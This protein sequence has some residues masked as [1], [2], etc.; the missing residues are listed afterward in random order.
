MNV[1]FAVLVKL[2]H[3]GDPAFREV[4]RAACVKA[5][6]TFAEE[7]WDAVRRR[8][9]A[10]ESGANVLRL[11]TDAADT[12]VKGMT[13]F[14][15]YYVRN[16]RALLARA[17]L[18][19][20]GGYGR[21]EMSPHSD[22]DVCLL[23]DANLD[24]DVEALNQYLMPLLWDIG[25]HTGYSLHSVSE[26]IEL[27]RQDPQVST[28]YAQARLLLGDNTTFARLRLLHAELTRRGAAQV[29]RHIRS[30]EHPETLPEAQRDLYNLQPDIKKNVGGLRDYHAA[31]WMIHYTYGPMSLDDL[32]QLG[33]LSAEERLRLLEALGFLWRIRN[34][35][36]FHTGKDQDRLTFAMQKHVA[37]T[38]GYGAATQG[39][40]DRFMQDYY[41]AAQW[42]RRFLR[43]ASR[44]CDRQTEMGFRS[45]GDDVS[46]DTVLEQGEMTVRFGTLH[47]GARDRNW[48]I[49]RPARLMEVFWES[50]RRKVPLSLD[51][52]RR[53][54][55]SLPLVGDAFCASDVVRRYFIAICSQPSQ[56]GRVL[57]QAANS[58]LLGA[59]L[60]EFAA[61]QGIVR[62]RDFHSFPV[63]E[64]TLRAIEA[65]A[66]MPKVEGAT[67]RV[68]EKAF[69]HV[70]DPHILVMAILF[71]DLGKAAGEAHT[72]EGVRLVCQIGARIGM[73]E[74][75]TERI[76]FLV[77]H[78]MR[79]T[80]IAFYRDTDDV[81]TISRFA[82]VMKTDE[83]LR[84]LLLLTYADLTAVGPTVWSE[85][86]GALLIKLFLKTERLLLGRANV[87]S[88]EAFWKLP[89]ANE[90]M[91]AAPD[92]LKPLVEDY[93]R[94]LGE[95]YF[96]AFSPGH[97]VRHME[98]LEEA[99]QS[100]LAVR[101]KTHGETGMSEVVVCTHDRPGLF[102]AITGSFTS[103]L[104]DVEAA[105]PFTRPDG[106]VVDCFTVRDAANG[107]PLTRTQFQ[108][109]EQVLRA[110]LLQREDIQHYVDRSRRRLFALLQPRVP[111][112]TRVEFDN[113]AS[114][115]DTVID[116]ETGDRT[117]LLYDIA[118]ALTAM[119]V[120]I[121]SARIMT[122]ARRVRDAFYVRKSEAKLEDESLQGAVRAG[123]VEAIQPVAAAEDKGGTG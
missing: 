42:M 87:A 85:W 106:L 20:L 39:A 12:L 5:A 56:A 52:E 31:M 44:I 70:R 83:R 92:P 119:D 74:D 37:Q 121:C 104:V 32:E 17:A 114:R 50:A 112:R 60:P 116:I 109:F 82:K 88:E 71:H 48:F 90:V 6:R 111:V 91:Q 110:V 67:P 86:K 23:Y 103:Q 36:H 99:R 102:A 16:R 84:E 122:D 75:D 15:L 40:I 27:A 115:T 26:A 41:A 117:G 25:F 118:R 51:T 64:H 97:I 1:E 14:G 21:R 9:D 10:G 49:E 93:L 63:D 58:G 69:E 18:C 113:E 53:V 107:R 45:G 7:Q 79:M 123:L 47:A 46:A 96:I 101:C 11:L 55:A 28:T 43:I 108:G 29:I 3:L 34:E 95:R 78:H 105:A 24:P 66:E 68:L 57:R 89:K 62:Y 2:A 73:P 80:E 38:F 77:E 72:R 13:E 59:Y 98:C 76:A 22:L 94:D 65:L 81:E 61:I 30:R 33:H 54:N 8:H 100:G 120:D 19:A 35:M 4:P